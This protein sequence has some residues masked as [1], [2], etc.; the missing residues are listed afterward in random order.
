MRTAAGILALI[1]AAFAL[2]LTPVQL[3]LLVGHHSQVE[4]NAGMFVFALAQLV[5]YVL[6]GV[7]LLARKRFGPPLALSACAVAFAWIALRMVDMVVE[8]SGLGP[9]LVFVYCIGLPALAV[10]ALTV[11]SRERA[12]GESIPAQ[13]F[14][15]PPVPTDQQSSLVRLFAGC[16][17]IAAVIGVLGVVAA[18]SPPSTDVPLPSIPGMPPRSGPTVQTG[19]SS[20]SGLPSD[21]GL[22]SEFPS[23]PS[24]PSFPTFPTF[25][26][27][28]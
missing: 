5:L 23:V 15:V 7:G 19:P 2:L 27:G 20:M 26:T 1:G 13:P 10:L 22:P 6:G 25:P 11:A 18:C 4:L 24:L 9:L 14:K 12:A 28:G 8:K 21:P 3:T 16:A 17:V